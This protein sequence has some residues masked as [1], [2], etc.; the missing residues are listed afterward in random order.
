MLSVVVGTT[1]PLYEVPL[2]SIRV[3]SCAHQPREQTHAGPG[4]MS[5]LT[6]HP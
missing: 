1:H 2:T 5:G 6:A 4:S 3:M